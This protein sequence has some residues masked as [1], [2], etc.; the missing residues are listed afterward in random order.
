[1]YVQS[2]GFSNDWADS[3]LAGRRD[4]VK[5]DTVPRSNN[6]PSSREITVGK[7]LTSHLRIL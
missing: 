2:E 6:R 3:A 5:E 1:M 7:R 4:G